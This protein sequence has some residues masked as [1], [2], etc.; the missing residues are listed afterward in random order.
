MYEYTPRPTDFVKGKEQEKV[1]RNTV[2]GGLE[3]I[4]YNLCGGVPYDNRPGYFWFWGNV[5]ADGYN[6]YLAFYFDGKGDVN[7]IAVTFA[8]P[9]PSSDFAE[10]RNKEISYGAQFSNW[11]P[12]D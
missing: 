11:M 8:S 2:T 12:K 6:C 5:I 1:F 3:S 10:K 9:N 7:K 4:K